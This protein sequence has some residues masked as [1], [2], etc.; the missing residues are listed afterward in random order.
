MYYYSKETGSFYK[1]E[2]HGDSIPADAVEITDEEHAALLVGQAGGKR[3]VADENG[4]PILVD[5]PAPEPAPPVY[6]RFTALEMLDLFTEPEQLA[7]VQATM[8]EA[9]VK[10]WYDRL[11]AADYVN[12]E[13]PRVDA[14]LQAL[15]AAGLLTPERKAE[16]VVAMQP[17]EP[18]AQP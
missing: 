12:Y 1:L 9:A 6:P 16:I 7:V 17:P 13:D 8:T 11:L 5:P 18:G 15:V 14:G 2:I 4:Y 3:I 10:L